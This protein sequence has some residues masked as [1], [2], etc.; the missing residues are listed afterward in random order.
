MLKSKFCS[1]QTQQLGLSTLG[2]ERTVRVV[3][4]NRQV[5]TSPH[6]LFC[7]D[8]QSVGVLAEAVKSL[9]EEATLT[10]QTIVMIGI[11][12]HP[13]HR[14][15]EYVAG[16]DDARHQRHRRFV[17]E[18]VVPWVESQLGQTLTRDQTGLLGISNGAIAAMQLGLEHRDLFGT[19]FSFSLVG[20]HER[21]RDEDFVLFPVPR[22]YL[23]AGS[24]EVPIRK[25]SER[26]A[27][28]LQKLGVPHN[29]QIQPNESHTMHLWHTQIATAIRWWIINSTS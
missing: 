20:G 25:T 8:G 14:A 3:V 21:Y 17:L 28:L 13:E 10:K 19:I 6:V 15:H 9:F 29:L 22:I 27:A 16:L 12:S 5:S 4:L 18:E 1:I 7:F 26:L 11:P 23:L 24:R 2:H